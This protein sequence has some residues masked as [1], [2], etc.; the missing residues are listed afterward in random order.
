MKSYWQQKL[1]NITKSIAGK[2]E[3]LRTRDFVLTRRENNRYAE[4]GHIQT[5]ETIQRTAERLGWEIT[6]EEKERDTLVAAIA[7]QA[8]ADKRRL[9]RRI[10]MDIKTTAT[11]KELAL[12]QLVVEL[13]ALGCGFD[14]G[15]AYISRA[16][17][18]EQTAL[19]RRAVAICDRPIPAL[20]H[21]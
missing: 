8:L 19:H 18:E 15:R 12:E 16:Y 3:S 11:A 13:L 4:Q 21:P 5:N 2:K 20:G 10:D 9:A 17:I 6:A 14:I 7:A 1:E